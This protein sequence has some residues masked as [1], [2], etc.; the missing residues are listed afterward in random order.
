MTPSWH[1]RPLAWRLFWKT[2]G[3]R[4][5]PVYILRALPSRGAEGP[6]RMKIYEV[7]FVLEVDYTYYTLVLGEILNVSDPS[8]SSYIISQ[9]VYNKVQTMYQ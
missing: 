2:A 9:R 3:R 6:L 4:S 7:W 8:T 1:Q 5:W